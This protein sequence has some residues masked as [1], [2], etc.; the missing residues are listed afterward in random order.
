M[1]PDA[2]NIHNAP[3]P[4]SF[5]SIRVARS[6]LEMVLNQLTIFFLDLELDDQFYDLAIN[7]AEK[8]LLFSPWLTA[9]E[10]AFASLLAQKEGSM[11]QEDRTAAMI[12][13]AHHVVAEILTDVDLSLGEL[14]WDEFHDK[15]MALRTLFS[16]ESTLIRHRPTSLKL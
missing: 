9:W 15:V 16:C 4:T 11:S 14:G 3:L 5:N 6:S 1:V 7:T 12:L 13:K 10:K 8:H 2:D